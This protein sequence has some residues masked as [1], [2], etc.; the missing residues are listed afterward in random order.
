MGLGLGLAINSSNNGNGNG[1]SG[2]NVAGKNANSTSG[3]SPE[4]L[5]KCAFNFPAVLYTLGRSR[6]DELRSVFLGMAKVDHCDVR[7]CIA[8]ALHEISA[9][10]GRDP[11]SFNPSRDLETVLAIFVADLDNIKTAV[12]EHLAET[13]T[14]LPASIRDQLLPG[15]VLLMRNGDHP[16]RLREIMANQVVQLSALTPQTVMRHLLPL[17]VQWAKDP[18]ASVR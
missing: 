10:L 7:L 8:S 2:D 5:Y 14:Y 17:A 6:W 16:W 9:I 4:M 13:L 18:V 11:I 1:N 15:L 3:S 12:I